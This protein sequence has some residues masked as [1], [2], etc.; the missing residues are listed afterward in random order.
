MKKV[1]KYEIYIFSFCIAL[2]IIIY[3]QKD[4]RYIASQTGLILY[5]ILKIGEE[6]VWSSED[7]G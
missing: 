1:L 5:V 2:V 3:S 6:E 7:N 4:I